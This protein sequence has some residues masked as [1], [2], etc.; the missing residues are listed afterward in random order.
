[1]TT[2]FLSQIDYH[3]WDRFIMISPQG[4]L[5]ARTTYLKQLGIPFEILVSKKEKEI[6]GG[7]VITKDHWDYNIN[8]VLC[9][10]LGVYFYPFEGNQ[11]K[12]ESRRRAV[13]KA[14]LD[15]VNKFNSFEYTFHPNYK[16]W[17]PFERAGYHL[18]L[19]HI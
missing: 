17:M 7:I 15:A 2:S 4:N 5:F 3:Q 16:N 6:K 19:I 10:Y 1:M 8:P 9:K 12:I 14:L 18:S 13:Q 11:Y